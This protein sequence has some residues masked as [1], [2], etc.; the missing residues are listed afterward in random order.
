[1]YIK[2]IK[3]TNFK[4]IY[5]TQ[6]FDFTNLDGLV[7]LSGVIGSGKTTLCEALLYGL[8]GN[9][10]GHKIPNLVSWNEKFC[11]IEMDLISRNKDIHIVRNSCMPLEIKVNGKLIAASNKRDTQAIL[12]EELY[13]VP[14]LAVEKMCIISFS[15]FNSLASMN[16][17]QTK[18]FLDEVFGFGTFTE[19]NNVVVDERKM[20]ISRN[21][22]LNAVYSDTEKQIQ[23]LIDKKT[24]QQE[25]L[26]NTIDIDGCNIL[27]EQ[28]IEQGK[29]KKEEFK[30]NKAKQEEELKVLQDDKQKIYDVKMEYATMG[31]QY[32][33]WYNTFKS[34]KCPTCGNEISKEAIEENKQKMYDCAEKFKEQQKIEDEAQTKILEFQTK[35]KKE[36]DDIK[37]DMEELKRQISNID[38]QIHTYNNS[39]ALLNENYDDLISEYR[40]KLAN[41]KKDI[42]HSDIEIGEWNDMNE[43]FTKTFR[44]NLLETLIPH[45]NKSIA[46]FINKLD[47]NYSI[48]YDQEFKP[49][50]KINTFDREISYKDLSTGQRKSLDLAIVFG[51]L[52][53]IIA[54]V[55]FNLF[56]LDELFSNMDADSR[57]TMLALLN[58][59]MATDRTIFVI[60]HAEMNDDYFS[61]KI[62]VH[63]EN[64]KIKVGT[65]KKEREYVVKSSKYEKVF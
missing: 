21:T 6:E 28:L 59:S 25:E 23:Y 3:I 40:I 27:R 20:Q 38:A 31:K 16:P 12:E 42:E 17:G 18:Q 51:I 13:D 14:K 7:K 35:S 64:K 32:K 44:Y 19:Y 39:L 34:G 46:Y 61:H 37:A 33:E 15:A 10:S 52:Q 22:E 45:I 50:I 4:S 53:N 58:D 47:Q 2:S 57:N 54:N 1:M 29:S 43:L 36:Q 26:K 8:F 62:K 30:V 63:L 24:K 9:V 65:G 41:I 11:E 60:N 5:G 49:H 55:N 56:C 48:T